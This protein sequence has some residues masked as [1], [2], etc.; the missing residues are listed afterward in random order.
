[1]LDNTASINS[2]V[3]VVEWS[4]LYLF[5]SLCQLTRYRGVTG[6]SSLI[7]VVHR[8]LHS[9]GLQ[10]RA[11]FEDYCKKRGTMT[12]FGLGVRWDWES[13]AHSRTVRERAASC[14]KT[15]VLTNALRSSN[16]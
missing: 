1:L 3:N 7:S 8:H 5:R 11:Q 15:R 13:N 9:T 4:V 2:L 16:S 12:L 14:V 10:A 6:R